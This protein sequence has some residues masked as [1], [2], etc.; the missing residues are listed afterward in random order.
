[1]T[2]EVIEPFNQGSEREHIKAISCIEH[3]SHT[4]EARLGWRNGIVSQ[5]AHTNVLAAH[6]AMCRS[7]SLLD[8]HYLQR[9]C[10]GEPGIYPNR[11]AVIGVSGRQFN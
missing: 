6:Q 4:V 10:S 1:M 5:L 11:K 3:P 2:S 7:L 9:L 8:V